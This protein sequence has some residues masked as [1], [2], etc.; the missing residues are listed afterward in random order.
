MIVTNQARYVNGKMVYDREPTAAERDA[1]A[2]RFAEMLAARRGPAMN[3]SD[4]AFNDDVSIRHHGLQDEPLGLQ[5]HMIS[6]ARRA[7]IN[8][9][10]K[11]FKGGIAERHLGA[12]D[13]KAW[14]SSFDEMVSVAAER[15]LIV[16]RGGKRYND[17]DNYVPPPEV[18]LHPRL[19]RD[20]IVKDCIA[21]PELARKPVAEL[22]AMV[23]EKYGR[24]SKFTEAPVTVLPKAIAQ[25]AIAKAK[26]K[27]SD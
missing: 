2:A 13:P 15:D 14:V 3:G 9:T 11:V 10:G 23:T 18:D 8:I 26:K 24:K 6:Q 20:M 22:K 17:D 25:E 4:Q 12:A 21:N 27:R 5:E 16:N 7:G 1:D 19:V